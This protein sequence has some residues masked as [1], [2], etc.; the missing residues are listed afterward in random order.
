LKTSIHQCRQHRET[1]REPARPR[2]LRSVLAISI[3]VGIANAHADTAPGGKI[4]LTLNDEISSRVDTPVPE[5]EGRLVVNGLIQSHPHELYVQLEEKYQALPPFTEAQEAI[6]ERYIVEAT[7][8]E[9]MLA[10]V[11]SFAGNASQFIPT[12]SSS[13]RHDDINEKNSRLDPAGNPVGRDHTTVLATVNPTFIYETERRKWHIKAR[14]DY[15]RARYFVDEDSSVNDHTIDMNWTRRLNRGQELSVATLYENT[16]DRRTKDPIEDFDSS[17]ESDQL[18]YNRTLVNLMYRNG[19]L[20]DRSRYEA[21]LFK[22]NSSVDSKDLL[23]NGYDLDRTGLGG[24][25]AWQVK[26]QM[27]LVAE[28]RYSQFD[29]DLAFRDN[30]HYRA[31]VGTDLIIGRRIRAILRV[32]YAEKTFDKS[33][34]GDTFGEPVW[35]GKLEWALRR[36]TSVKLE[37]G[38]EIYELATAD[39]PIDITK[40]NIQDWVRTVWAERWTDKLSTETSYT[41][42]DTSFEGRDNNEDAQQFIVSAI[43]Q[44]GSNL[45]FAIDGAY[46]KKEDDLGEDVSR[47]TITFRT[48]YSL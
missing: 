25:Y 34:F 28:G 42:R 9:K 48:D 44:A 27:S 5:F 40:F 8:P 4:R 14:Y 37:T 12:I 7:T 43:Y 46:T 11:K 6:A 33:A 41:Y 24:S 30:T 23:S 3:S 29:Y 16:H 19:T 39:R 47:R 2:L 36:K 26:K 15:V 32:G 17:L 38:R 21:F 13:I 31:L 18:D 45:R 22:E 35:S 1:P 20:R 10:G